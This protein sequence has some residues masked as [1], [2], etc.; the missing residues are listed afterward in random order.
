M[1]KDYGPLTWAVVWPIVLRNGY[2]LHA[3]GEEVKTSVWRYNLTKNGLR[4]ITNHVWVTTL[5]IQVTL[6]WLIK[7]RLLTTPK[8]PWIGKETINEI[9]CARLLW[10]VVPMLAHCTR[11]N[12]H[13]LIARL[14]P[15]QILWDW[16]IVTKCMYYN[17]ETFNSLY[18]N[19]RTVNPKS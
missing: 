19:D 7:S 16:V 12:Q 6:N 18:L 9:L 15:G 14:L 4:K 17:W 11:S 1:N 10:M 3:I 8:C 2:L 13:E 5:S